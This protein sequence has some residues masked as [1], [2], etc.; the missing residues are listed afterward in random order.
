[1]DFESSASGNGLNYYCHVA[2]WTADVL[3]I[4]PCEREPVT[5]IERVGDS[6]VLN[7]TARKPPNRATEED[8]LIL[9]SRSTSK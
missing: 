1:M 2:C 6:I 8:R 4:F 9:G 5:G 3:S 7:E